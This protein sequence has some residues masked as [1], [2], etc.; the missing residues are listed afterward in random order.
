MVLAGVLAV[1][2]I[3]AMGYP[4]LM[5]GQPAGT[6][7][8]APIVTEGSATIISRPEGAQVLI[9]GVAR[10]ATPLKISLPIGSYTLELQNG[11]AKRSLPLVIEAGSTVRQYVDLAP[12]GTMT[13]QI[14]VTSE[15]A[16][17]Q[18]TVDGVPRGA[19][20]LLVDGIEPGQ[21]AVVISQG[22][23]AVNRIVQ[24]SAGTTATVVAS[25]APSG[26]AG[27]W[28]TLN[29]PIDLQVLEAG[30]LLGT[31]SMERLMLPAGR[32]ELEL[33][34]SA[35]DFRTTVQVVVPAGRT[36][37]VNVSLPKGTLSINALPW[38]E[39]W[40]D[41]QPLGTT[42]LGNVAVP[43]GNHELIWRHPQHGERRQTVK[44]TAQAPVRA[45][46]DFTK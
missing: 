26:A 11:T 45:G 29:T 2:A 12:G 15:P 42:P 3:A 24:V 31:S 34:S 43:I 36:T 19:T 23:T 7:P 30:K 17:A 6:P 35:F 21:H 32:H 18:V 27:G 4:W 1:G 39:V 44:V 16:G 33:A 9:D 5:K 40:L 28:I 8:A 14:E 37:T 20:P 22:G 25:V 38:A 10:G 41:G 46:V 13:G